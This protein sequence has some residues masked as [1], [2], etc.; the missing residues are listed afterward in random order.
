MV[1]PIKYLSG[2]WNTTPQNHLLCLE[3]KTLFFQVI[4]PFCGFVNPLII[5]SSVV[6]PEPLLPQIKMISFS[7]TFKF[8]LSI[9]F[10]HLFEVDKIF[11]LNQA[12][13]IKL[14]I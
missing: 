5:S 14:W 10:F 4:F 8:K 11:L 9:I 13:L 7:S 1:V 12:L 3:D 2:N 6:F